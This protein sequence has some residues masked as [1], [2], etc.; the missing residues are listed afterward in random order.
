MGAGNGD[1]STRNAKIKMYTAQGNLTYT[2]T[3]EGGSTFSDYAEYFE[4]AD[5][6]KID[7]GYLVSLV[8]NKIKKADKGEIIIGAISETAGTVLGSAAFAWQDRYLKNEFG[9]YIYEKQI[10]KEYDLDADGNQLD[11]YK[12]VLVDMPKENPDYDPQREYEPRA[13]RDE[14]H[15]VGLVGQIHVRVDDTVEEGDKI[16]AVGGIGTKDTEGQFIVMNIT[17]PYDS[18]KGYGVA[19]VFIR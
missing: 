12:K 17:T 16:S 13:E 5:G 15:I 11:T 19:V 8:G 14:W 2:G 7:T 9:G 18:D 10:M 4:S 6:Q 1:P 3:S